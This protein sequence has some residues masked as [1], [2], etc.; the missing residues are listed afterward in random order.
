MAS[1]IDIFMM[2]SNSHVGSKDSCAWA[3]GTFYPVVPLCQFFGSGGGKFLVLPT[4]LQYNRHCVSFLVPTGNSLWY[5][6]H[7]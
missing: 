3:G 4:Y 5:Y 2:L 6:L 7:S 1:P